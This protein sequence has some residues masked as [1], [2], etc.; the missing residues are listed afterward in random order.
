MASQRETIGQLA[1]ALRQSIA[2]LR[3]ETYASSWYVS[4]HLVSVEARTFC[5]PPKEASSY[6]HAIINVLSSYPRPPRRTP[7]VGPS[8]FKPVPR[9]FRQ[10]FRLWLHFFKR[11]LPARLL[12]L[13]LWIPCS[14]E[15]AVSKASLDISTV[16]RTFTVI[17]VLLSLLFLT[18]TI[19][20]P[21][22]L[23]QTPG[24]SLYARADAFL[25][26]AGL[27]IVESTLDTLDHLPQFTPL[28]DYTVSSGYG[29]RLHPL[30]Y[31]SSFH[32]GVDLAAEEGSPIFP[33]GRG[34]IVEIGVD[35]G[36]GVFVVVDHSPSPYRTLFGHLRSHNVVV[37]DVVQPSS[38]IAQVGSSGL[39][40]GPH[41]HYQIYGP[42]GPVDPQVVLRRVAILRDSLARRLSRFDVHLRSHVS[43]HPRGSYNVALYQKALKHLLSP[44]VKRVSY[45]F[46]AAVT[47]ADSI[48]SVSSRNGQH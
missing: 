42:S 35:P 18:M 14:L 43:H 29:R 8:L 38:E 4:T 11:S 33:P 22:D 41:L 21:L 39:S 31:R 26:I 17:V 47:P 19:D 28:N 36:Y 15:R 5:V 27:P 6:S 1:D 30:T 37:G 45:H 44:L 12:L 3:R 34:R 9:T 32:H 46:P 23:A 48:A 13:F 10:S 40:T 7:G 24:R 25:E 2:D 20:E 16:E